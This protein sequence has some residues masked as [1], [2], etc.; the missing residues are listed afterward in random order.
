M[1]LILTF[2]NVVAF[3]LFALSSVATYRDIFGSRPSER[4]CLLLKWLGSAVLVA[5]L[6]WSLLQMNLGL[7]LLFWFGDMTVVALSLALM[8]TLRAELK[9]LRRRQST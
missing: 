4:R 3:S 7:A 8:L 5:A 6:G 1:L 9:Q 2:I